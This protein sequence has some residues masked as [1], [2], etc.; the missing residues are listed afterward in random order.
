MISF[1]PSAATPLLL[2][3]GVVVTSLVY[4]FVVY[5]DRWRTRA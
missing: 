4:G 5:L 1:S 2:L 3:M